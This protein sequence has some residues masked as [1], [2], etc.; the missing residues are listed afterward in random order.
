MMMDFPYIAFAKRASCKI[1]FSLRIVILMEP[2]A[3]EESQNTRCFAALSMT[4]KEFCKSLKSFSDNPIG[5][6]G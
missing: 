4:K 1:H 2:Q 3:T 5:C 6:R